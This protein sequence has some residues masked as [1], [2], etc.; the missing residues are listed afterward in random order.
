MKLLIV[1]IIL[2]C[3]K[4]WCTNEL[5]V[6]WGC[7]HTV[8]VAHNGYRFDFPT[9]LAEI[10]RRPEKLAL[11]QLSSHRIHFSDTLGHLKQVSFT[12]LMYMNTSCTINFI[13]RLRRMDMV[14][15]NQWPSSVSRASF[16]IFLRK[17]RTQVL[18]S[19]VHIWLGCT[20][21]LPI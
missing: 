7:L 5:F 6:K 11:S 1:T 13:F 19:I 14:H 8:L 2:V 21:D 15:W 12:L 17:I 4:H 20:P 10:E 16:I 18:Y 9:L 3:Q